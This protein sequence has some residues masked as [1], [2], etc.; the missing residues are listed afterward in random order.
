M[1]EKPETVKVFII[2]NTQIMKNKKRKFLKRGDTIDLDPDDAG[3]LFCQ[4]QALVV[5]DGTEKEIKALKEVI[6][7]EKD[8]EKA[9]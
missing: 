9:K 1:A 2:A 8:K 4:R 6:K 7:K 5:N 3:L